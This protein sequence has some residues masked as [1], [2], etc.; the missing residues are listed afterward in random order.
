MSLRTTL[1]LLAACA[2][3]CFAASVFAHP[4]GQ[5]R[6]GGHREAT[7]QY[8]F[9]SGPLRGQTF[10]SKE[11]ALEALAAVEPTPAPSE[12]PSPPTDTQ[13]MTIASWN[14]RN[15]STRSR[16][17]AELGIISLIIARYDFIALQ[18]VLDTEVIGRIQR[19]L[20]D[21]FQ[22]EYGADVSGQVGQN[23]KECY[24]FL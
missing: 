3:V 5:D 16:S 14:V 6:N 20:A 13:T 7:G 18:E 24:A 23:K 12:V 10:P 4:G 2:L 19:I 17:D 22:L 21:D 1:T 11:D 15:L 9:H 8:H